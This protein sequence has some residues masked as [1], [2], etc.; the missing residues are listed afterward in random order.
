MKNVPMNL[1]HQNAELEAL[2]ARYA[3]RVAAAL[4]EQAEGIDHGV[5]ERL[6]FAREQALV[7]ARAARSAAAAPF[8]SVAGNGS[9]TLSMAGG[10]RGSSPWWFRMA[11]ALPLLALVGGLVLIQSQHVRH[12]ISAAAEIDLDLLLDDLPPAAYGDPGFV[13]YLK[14]NRD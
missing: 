7:R 1:S 4:S 5:S 11:S 14:T 12:Q 2:Q 10:P 3:L 8:V 6:R 9:A 13:E